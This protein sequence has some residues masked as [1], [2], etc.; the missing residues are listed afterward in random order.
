MS[1]I[2]AAAAGFLWV[3]WWGLLIAPGLLVFLSLLKSRSSC[4]KQR[5]VGPLITFAIGIL[6]A[7]AF[8]DQGVG[9]VIFTLAV[10]LLYL[11]EKM[12]YALPVLFFSIL[13][14]SNYDLVNAVY[15]KPLD[16]F[17]LKMG[18]PLMWHVETPEGRIP[19]AGP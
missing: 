19:K 17:N 2:V 9:F 16:N 15:E 14:L 11:A 3:H 12:L 10:S 7:F 4:G 6:F 18:I 1:F 5:I 13:T 8:R